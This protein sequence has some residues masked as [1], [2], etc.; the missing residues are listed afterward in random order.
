M[1]AKMESLQ[2]CRC[3]ASHPVVSKVSP[4]RWV[5]GCGSCPT[6]AIGSTE[7]EA[8]KNWNVEVQRG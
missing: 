5:V 7:A 8:R 6:H 2:P 3:G 4:G 1:E